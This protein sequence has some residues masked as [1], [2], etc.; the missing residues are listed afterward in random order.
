MQSKTIP[1]EHKRILANLFLVLFV[2][3][4]SIS[5]SFA[6]SKGSISG[7]ISDKSNN[8][9][10]IGANVLIVGTTTGT[11]SDLDGSY[12]LRSLAPGRYQ[13]RFSYIS[14]QATIVNNVLV[15][16][17][18]DT[19][20]NVQLESSTAELNEVVVSA[21]ALKS[22]EAAILN[23]QKNSMSIVDGVSAELIKKNNSAD[24]TDV[25]K[26]MTGVTISD[27]KYAYIRGVSD[28]Y[29]STMLNGANLPSTDP[30]KKSVSYDLF[31]SSLIENIITSKSATP[32]KPADF[33]GGLVQINTVEFPAKLLTEFSVGS[34]F[35]N[36]TTGKSSLSYSGGKYDFLGIDDGT[37]DLPSAVPR[38][39]VNSSLGQQKIQDI[40]KAFKNDWGTKSGTMPVNSNFKITL[41]NSYQVGDEGILGYIGSLTYSNSNEL[42]QYQRNYY[43]YSGIWYNYNG[44]DYLNNVLWGALF[45]LSYK[46][47]GNNKISFKNIYNQNTDNNVVTTKGDHYYVPEYREATSLQFLERSLYSTQLV[48]E[49]V[50][51]FFNNSVLNWNVNYA[52]SKRKEPDTRKYWYSRELDAPE[53]D[54]RFSM[55]Q[56]TATRFFSDLS[57]KSYGFSGDLLLKIFDDPNLPNLKIGY[58]QNK[59]DRSYTP[60]VFGFDF[61]QRQTSIELRDSVFSLPVEEIFQPVNINPSF[62]YVVEVSNPSDKYGATEKI[63][64]AYA[65][66]NTTL[67]NDFKFTGGFRF[68]YSNVILN[69]I[70]PQ[71]RSKMLAVD[72]SYND[73]LPSLNFTYKLNEEINVR[74]AY[75]KTLARPEL[76]ELAVSGYYDFL[77]DDYVFGNPDLQRTLIDNYDF[78]F[79]YYP[80]PTELLAA[81]LFYKH[82]DNPIEVIG[83]NTSTKS[84]SWKNADNAKSYGLEFEIRKSFSFLSESL[85]HLSV[86][87]NISFIKSEVDL[88]VAQVGQAELVQK[89]SLQGQAD[90]VANVGLYYDNYENGLTANLVYNKVGQK[91]V[92]VGVDKT[93]DILSM[94]RDQIDFNISKKVYDNFTLKLAV[95]DLLAQDEVTIQRTL[96]GDKTADSLKR[97]RTVS[98][99]ISYQLN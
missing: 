17:G 35:N 26:R 6:Q 94:P 87:G 76:R 55:N 33:S 25:L 98:L 93:G 61:N 34:S 2:L 47:G 59:K 1:E 20:V 86:I 62:I 41:G 77:T 12:S 21:E 91:I 97:G 38:E 82:F 37:R 23:I 80:N 88:G 19:R 3:F 79:E 67:F 89:R 71:S 28:R 64:S 49:H 73:L 15:E 10:L 60:R 31:P 4:V 81:N 96:E 58:L 85:N 74:G 13:L 66:F 75:G 8:E 42:R 9:D 72:H 27:G 48:G 18:K 83:V 68:E 14:Y 65:M 92:E 24:G 29:N 44:N 16:A 22:T 11:S 54:L 78:R 52:D 51:N 5:V 63:Q 7:K 69:Y 46:L 53:S 43:N 36:V 45:N 57:D 40:G 70:D 32:D 95:K 30:E 99:G 39:N 84:R 90:Y 56:A 50:L